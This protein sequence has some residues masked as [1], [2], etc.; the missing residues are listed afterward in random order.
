MKKEK[1]PDYP[2]LS[3]VRGR[4]KRKSITDPKSTSEVEEPVTQVCPE[5]K[6]LLKKLK[7][8]EGSSISILVCDNVYCARYR[9]PQ[10][11]EGSGPDPQSSR[12]NYRRYGSA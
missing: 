7:W 9:R 2:S 4:Q 11:V 5:C 12:R 8:E 1:I 10:E 3:W 6:T